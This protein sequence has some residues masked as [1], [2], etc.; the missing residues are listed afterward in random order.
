VNILY[1]FRVRGTGAEAVH[2]AGIA[3]G[4][5]ACGHNVSF[6]SPTGVDPTRPASTASPAAPAAAAAAAPRPLKR[7][8]HLLADRAPQPVFEAMELGYNAVAVPRLLRA[9]RER[10]A[11]LLYER[12][13]FFNL[14]GTVA[15]R[16]LGIPLVVEVNELAGYERVR[17]QSFVRLARAVERTVMRRAS[18]I[19]TVSQFLTARCQEIVDGKVPVVTV[20][21]GVSQE[22]LAR[23]AAAGDSLQL[24]R[25]LGLGARPVLCFVGGLTHWHNF[26]LL[27]QALQRV[28]QQLPA[29]ALLVVGDGPLRSFIQGE[30]ARLGLSD[31]VVLAGQVPH[32]RIASYIGLAEVGV[33]PETNQYRS[34]IKMFEYMG[35][36][37]VVVAPHMPP[38]EAVIEPERTGLL[39]QPGSAESLARAVV[40]ALCDRPLAAALGQAAR[41]QI[42]HGYTWEEHARRILRLARQVASPRAP[43]LFP[44]GEPASSRI[45]A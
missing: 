41:Q 14:A 40:R 22:W 28:R 19:V 43:C 1:H 6:M 32:E 27:L 9:G 24:R 13:A 7:L 36:G 16:R 35:A 25:Q 23:A 12:Y 11:D 5:R 42:R 37:K 45:L 38:V 21:N 8:L 18:L 39:F 20:P 31:S 44:G 15:S 26:G 4:F 2:I 17:D 30:A 33:I 10:Q 34:P 3:R 29:A